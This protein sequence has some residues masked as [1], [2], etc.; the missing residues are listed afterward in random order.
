MGKTILFVAY[1]AGHVRM[2][3]PV[4]RELQKV[5]GLRIEVLGLTLAQPVLAKEGIAYHGFKDF[6]YPDDH[7][8]LAWGR[9][10]AA[11]HHKPDS[12]I[13]EDEAVAYLGLCYWELVVRNGEEAA[14]AM[15]QQQG[16]H[17]FYPLIALERVIDCIKPDLVVTTNSPRSERAAVTVA[18]ARGIP[19]LSMVDLV[20]I[21]HFHALEATYITVLT[22]HA[23]D[24]MIAEGVKRPREAFHITGNPAFDAA[25]D[26]A[27]PR[28]MAWR[29]QHFPLLADDAKTLLWIDVSG[30]WNMDTLTFHTRDDAEVLA[31]L[32]RVAQAAKMHNTCLLV[33][34]H[35]TQ[36]KALFHDWLN[37]CGHTH[38]FYA[39]EIPL[40][41]LLQVVDVVA[42]YNSTTCIEAVLMERETL[43]LKPY[44]AQH[45]LPLGEWGLAWLAHDWNEF[46]QCLG[47]ALYDRAAAEE[48]RARAR[49]LLP[50]ER[51]APKVAT[52]ICDILDGRVTAAA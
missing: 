9:K 12:G 15:W 6:L 51:A 47:E 17:A 21:K 29:R 25:Q 22:Q 1:G 10:L 27:G 43:M 2:I 16:R 48:K 14:A 24:N 33:R 44:R 46:S 37:A 42:S 40:Y 3:I 34:P 8:A 32:E 52:L 4:I 35:P 19:S 20:G 45:D 18:N 13:S 7:E 26:Y 41:P 28:D 31:D 39:G 30:Y 49:A 36:R 11:S 5:P 23:I 50:A 38:V